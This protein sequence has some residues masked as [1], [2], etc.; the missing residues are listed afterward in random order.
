[1]HKNNFK[2]WLKIKTNYLNQILEL[3]KNQIYLF[4]PQ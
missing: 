4:A 2:N 1:M 3:P